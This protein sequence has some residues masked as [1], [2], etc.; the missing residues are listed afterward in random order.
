[1]LIQIAT[2]VGVWFVSLIVSSAIGQVLGLNVFGNTAFQTLSMGAVA[3]V[4]FHYSMIGLI[5]V[6]LIVSSVVIIK[7]V[8]VALLALYSYRAL[9]GSLGDEA[10]W[11]AEFIKE[12]DQEFTRA[13]S[14]LPSAELKEVKIIAE[15]KS[16]LRELTIQRYEQYND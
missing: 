6:A 1:M 16:E 3:Y 4:L 14:A 11:A 7:L 8:G 15:S 12:G 13:M 2:V 5:G 10:Q 9:Q